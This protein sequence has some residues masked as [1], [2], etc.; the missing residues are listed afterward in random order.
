[1]QNNWVASERTAVGKLSNGVQNYSKQA[2][3]KTHSWF[4]SLPPFTG[5]QELLQQEALMKLYF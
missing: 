1:M 3:K 4:G 5:T 2:R